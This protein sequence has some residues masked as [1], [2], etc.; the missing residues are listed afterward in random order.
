MF[1]HRQDLLICPIRKENK[2]T[3]APQGD[4]SCFRGTTPLG[5]PK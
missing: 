2:K 4:G 3:P 1:T 5:H